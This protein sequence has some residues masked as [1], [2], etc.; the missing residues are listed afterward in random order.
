MRCEEPTVSEPISDLSFAALWEGAAD[1]YP[2]RPASICD[3]EA[4]TWGQF[5]RRAACLASLFAEHGVGDGDAVALYLRD[6]TAALESQFAAF[7]VGASPV[8]VATRYTTDD[9]VAILAATKAKVVVFQAT[10]SMRL[11]EI[12]DRLADVR[13]WIQ[14]SDGTEA[15]MAFAQDYERSIRDHEPRARMATGTG[16]FLALSA[17]SSGA[18]HVVAHR[19]SAFLAEL[20]RLGSAWHDTARVESLAD[21]LAQIAARR[22]APISVVPGSLM[23]GPAMWLGALLPL[24]LGG[25]VV[26]TSKLD[27]D[28][29]RA[30]ALVEDHR[31]T[32]LY[33]GGEAQARELLGAL[34][35]AERRGTPFD[36]HALKRI[37]SSGCVW[38]PESRARLRE[39]HDMRLVDVLMAAEGVI[40]VALD[41]SQS[42]HQAGA[43]RPWPGVEVSASAPGG[44]VA[45]AGPTGDIAGFEGAETLYWQGRGERWLDRD[46]ARVHAEALERALLSHDDVWDALVVP[47][48][49]RFDALVSVRGDA[50]DV[51]PSLQAIMADHGNLHLVERVVRYSSGKPNLK[52]G[53]GEILRFDAS[54]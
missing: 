17:G 2:Q 15:L 44:V 42:P 52:W 28:P 36:L 47:G 9:L 8:P 13:L 34:D 32:D 46:G 49:G 37:V 4:V 27:F 6:G 14:V 10:Y 50:A 48:E 43:F 54:K 21:A 3:G 25:A 12:K 41:D 35:Q 20:L 19:A 33:I 23:H 38:L 30:L 24:A 16:E 7:K 5:E 53:R 11:W 51:E 45:A 40:G 18:P 29:V 31:A 1:A 22:R 39:H 26:S